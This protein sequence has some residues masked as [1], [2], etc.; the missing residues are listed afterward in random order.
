M[1]DQKIAISTH[2]IITRPPHLSNGEISPKSVKD[3]ENHCLNYFV[4]AKN[5]IEDNVKVTRILGCF[6]NDL[7]NDWIS[8]HRDR[9]TKLSFEVFMVEF[10]ARWLPHDWEQ[11]LRS[12]ILSA[13]L[14]PKKQCFEEWAAA[15]QSIN[16]SLRGTPSHL[17][18]DHIRLQLEAGLDEDL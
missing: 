5:G 12:K 7:V 10:H 1:S 11:D 14:Y 8:V 4:N 9:F 6:E 13:R 2:L 16:I 15:I 18:D 3:F 17:D